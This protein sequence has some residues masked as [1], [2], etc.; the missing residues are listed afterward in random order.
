[1]RREGGAGP[2]A[3]TA[4][5]GGGRGEGGGDGGGDDCGGGDGSG[6]LQ[7]DTRR[8]AV[9]M[10]MTCVRAAARVQRASANLFRR[11]EVVDDGPKKRLKGESDPIDL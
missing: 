4:T 2:G 9:S 8:M 7:Q 6:S 5:T 1:M 10:C 3:A 11:E